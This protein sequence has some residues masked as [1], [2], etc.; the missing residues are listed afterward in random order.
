MDLK[1]ALRGGYHGIDPVVVMFLDDLR[2][3][4]PARKLK[5]FRQTPSTQHAVPTLACYYRY[6]VNGWIIR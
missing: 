6:S 1:R 3:D 4:T 2:D 5:L